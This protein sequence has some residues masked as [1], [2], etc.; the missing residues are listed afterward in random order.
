MT[1]LPVHVQVLQVERVLHTQAHPVSVLFHYC[2][3]REG[4]QDM[5]AGCCLLASQCL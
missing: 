1:V 4:E 3:E 2:T 5:H